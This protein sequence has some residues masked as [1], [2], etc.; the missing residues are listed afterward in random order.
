M[1]ERTN[2]Y[3]VLVTKP[4]RKGPLRNFIRRQEDNIKMDAVSST[5]S[6]PWLYNEYSS[7][8]VNSFK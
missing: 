3:R 8:C 2:A 6:V 5:R 4:E 1:G 7:R